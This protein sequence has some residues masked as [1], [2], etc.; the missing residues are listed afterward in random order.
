MKFAKKDED[1]R[2]ELALKASN[3]GVWDWDLLAGEIF[4]SNRVLGF[5]GYGQVDAPNIFTKL[6]EHVHP[7]H[8]AAF[9][10]KLERLL[11]RNGRLLAIEPQIK[12][13]GGEWKWFRV[14][15]TPVRD[16][17]GRLI[18]LVGSMI[19]ISKRKNTETALAEEQQRIRLLFENIPV[20][21]YF[22]DGESRFVRANKATAQRLGAKSVT[23][24]I[25]K[26]D[27]DFFEAKHANLA[28]ASE[29]KIMQ[30][31]EA[32]LE[33]LEHEIWDDGK[34]TWVLVSKYPW[35]GA[36]GEIKGTFGITEDMTELVKAQEKLAAV[37][38]QL[39]DMNQDIEEER[40]LLR[41]V[42]D[43]IPMYVYFKDLESNFVLA[44]QGM[45]RLFELK[46]PQEIVRKHDRDFFGEQYAAVASADE[47]IIMESGEPVLGRLEKIPWES[48]R[49]TWSL[50]SKFPW[51][52]KE[53]HITGTFGVSGDVSKLVQ[54]RNELEKVAEV[55][56]RKN[57]AIQEELKLAREVQQAAIPETLPKFR[58]DD[59][60]ASFYHRYE[61]ASDLA[62]DFFEVIPLGNDRA[63]FLV[64]D[65]MG[66]GVRA[67]LIVSMLRGLMEK[68]L[69]YAENPGQ[70]LTNLNRG[71]SHLFE[72][73][74]LTMFATAIYGVV[75]LHSRE[76]R[77]SLAGH[78]APLVK[79]GAEIK[80]LPVAAED[81]GPALGLI[82]ESQYREQKIILNQDVEA[83]LCF[84]DGILE[85]ENA[86]NEEFGVS[87]IQEVL[88]KATDLRLGMDRVLEAGRAHA[89]EKKFADDICL[90]GLEIRSA[91]VEA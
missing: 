38:A 69:K 20:N 11:H 68:E 14:R 83:L 48:G 91:K 66:H 35:R 88:T 58:T 29:E 55:L 28:R 57:Q 53:G 47:K 40:H 84:T 15:A 27:H 33:T 77:I 54:T 52:D 22:K 37:T 81:K 8:L 4:Y 39:S 45:S 59:V 82:Q 62:G 16:E 79:L 5:L 44:N 30:T 2:L 13:K 31:G 56:A 70:F 71:L 67:A 78:P 51:F 46:D 89:R 41:L 7:D 80:E 32:I 26:T 49:V 3:E 43:N 24:L 9:Q 23:D 65:V 17:E 63:G 90:L 73:I 86:E 85:V 34:D 25:G 60:V 1:D 72:R 18:R 76:I 87:R 12:T 61:P 36:Y 75:D 64:C 42:I 74:S 50:T 6:D 21:I 10:R 19:D